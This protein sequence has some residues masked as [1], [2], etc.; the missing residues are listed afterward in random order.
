MDAVLKTAMFLIDWNSY[1]IRTFETQAKNQIVLF[2]LNYRVS[3]LLPLSLE[4][5][6]EVYIVCQLILMRGSI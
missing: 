4:N 2:L 5:L 6:L 3:H 1:A